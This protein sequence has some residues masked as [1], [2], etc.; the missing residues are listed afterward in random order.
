VEPPEDGLYLLFERILYGAGP[1]PT[2]GAPS[3]C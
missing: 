2:G 3:A 1:A